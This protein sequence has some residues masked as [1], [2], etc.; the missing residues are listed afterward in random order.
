[1][2]TAIQ[3][4]NDEAFEALDAGVPVE[5]LI[6]IDA[7]ARLNRMNTQDDWE[8]YIQELK[9]DTTEQLRELY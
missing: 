1:M 2:L 5:E 3:H 7:V 8:S 4:F 6:D 9:S